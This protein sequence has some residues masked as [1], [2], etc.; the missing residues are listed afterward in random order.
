MSPAVRTLTIICTIVLAGCGSELVSASGGSSET[1]D[2]TDDTGEPDGRACIDENG[3]VPSALRL[4]PSPARAWLIEGGVEIELPLEGDD[5]A[6]SMVGAANGDLLAI[7]RVDIGPYGRISNVQVFSRSSGEL[8]WTREFDG[9]TVSRLWVGE[10]GLIAGAPEPPFPGIHSGF[11][12]SQDQLLELPDHEPQ[13]APTL[14]HIAVAELNTS[15]VWMESGWLELANN[16]WHPASPEP[17]GRTA[18]LAEDGHTLEYFSV[19]DGLAWF[20]RAR[21]EGIQSIALPFGPVDFDGGPQIFGPERNHGYR[22]VR[23]GDPN[24]TESVA[25]LIDIEAGEATLVDP[26]LPQGWSFFDCVY[27]RVTVDGDGRLVYELRN[28]ASA[29]AWSYDVATDEWTPLGHDLGLVNYMAVEALSPDVFLVKGWAQVVCEAHEWTEAPE[30]ALIG[31]SRQ[32]VRRDPS[33]AL[34]LPADTE[35]VLIDE[36]QR[37]AASVGDNGWEVRPL[38]GSEA[39]LEAGPASAS[40]LWLD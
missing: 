3:L 8:L 20:D 26:E 2:G 11:V 12:M 35:Q 13:G 34:V 28:D 27:R 37:C 23:Y 38:D 16:S 21:P 39:V 5:E 9:V 15:G 7:A 25:A 30:G 31:D 19:V 14:G 4:E 40:W 1:G 6:V 33:L 22:V 32:L 18:H 17:G 36:Q 10:D 24:S 29:R